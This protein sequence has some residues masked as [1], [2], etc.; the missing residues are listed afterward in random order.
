MP[1]KIA[2]H[3]ILVIKLGA[4]GDVILSAGALRDIR[5]NHPNARITALTTPAYERIMERCPF[6]D[7]VEI[8][9]RAPRIALGPLLDLRRR[10]RAGGYDMVY[11]LQNS[12]RT[13]FYRRFM[14]PRTPWSGKAAGCSHPYTAANPERIPVLDRLAGQLAEA[15]LKVAHAGRPDVSWMADDP[16]GILEQ[17]GV[18]DGFILLVPGSAARHPQKRWPGYAALARRLLAEGHQVITAPGSDELDLCRAI[19]GI[20]LLDNGAPVDFFKLAG[21]AIR[22]RFVVGN[23]TGPTHLAAHAGA[24]GLA[25]YGTP[26]AAVTCIDRRFKVIEVPDL[27]TLTVETVYAAVR[28]ELDQGA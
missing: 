12:G 1:M 8:D 25:L 20:M 16:S 23:D 21:L 26:T 24:R 15:G 6:V 18:S 3:G 5:A 9:P 14:L 17:A 22:A 2:A 10:L 27:R 11:D 4:F 7:A 28:A 13:R 19:P